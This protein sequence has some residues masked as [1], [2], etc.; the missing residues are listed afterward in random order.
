MVEVL[1]FVVVEPKMLDS[2]GKALKGVAGVKEVLGITGEYDIIVRI[3]AKD[4]ESA[5]KIVKE[6][7]L[8]IE[9]IRKTITSIVVEKY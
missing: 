5:L 1:V 7:I 4:L 8:T 9:G 6:S 2:V 3:E